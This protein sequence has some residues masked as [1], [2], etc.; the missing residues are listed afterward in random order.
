MDNS[1]TSILKTL[2][3][4]TKTDRWAMVGFKGLTLKPKAGFSSDYFL[5]DDQVELLT[6]RPPRNISDLSASFGSTSLLLKQSILPVVAW[7]DGGSV[8]RRIG[9]SFLI[10]CSGY[11]MTAC[12]VLIDPEERGYG[13]VVRN[14]NTLLFKDELHMGVLLALNPAFFG[15][16]SFMFF[17]FQ[18]SWCL[19]SWKE[20]PLF[21][22]RDTFDI[23]T[24]VAICKISEMPNGAAHQPLS[25][26]LKAFT[27]G[28]QA[29]AVGYSEMDDVALLAVDG[30]IQF[31]KFKQE[32][33]VSVGEVMDV[34]PENHLSRDVPAPGPCFAFRA[35]VPG[36]MSGSPI[37]GGDGAVVRGVV[38][39]SFS[40]E[41]HSYGAM[42]GPV[43]RLPLINSMS[44]KR[45]MD[46]QT[47]GIAKV[48]GAG[49]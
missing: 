49:F 13:R 35:R 40:S 26:S 33:Y 8:V 36:K 34:H 14:G 10:S 48:Q 28:E 45:M 25:L 42:L 46:A 30:G 39:R 11:L 19:G 23:L 9:T 2:W 24:D 6:S 4:R 43:M 15:A 20:S 21:H 3:T 32:I 22:E 37:F 41:R 17:P 5:V 16:R 29:C 7:T 31:D 27:K 12:H 1:Q 18:Q 44:L 47:E 38:S